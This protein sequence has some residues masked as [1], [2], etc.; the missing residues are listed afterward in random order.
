[1]P[2]SPNCS[3]FHWNSQSTEKEN[4]ESS[5][6]RWRKFRELDPIFITLSADVNAKQ[7]LVPK[8]TPKERQ[9]IQALPSSMDQISCFLDGC[10]TTLSVL[11][12]QCQNQ[13][14]L[15]APL[16]SVHKIIKVAMYG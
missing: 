4:M 16:R 13:I 3:N 2:V 12:P 15:Y 10:Y 14:F 9:L 5:M 11:R 8:F 7:V 1:L 6:T